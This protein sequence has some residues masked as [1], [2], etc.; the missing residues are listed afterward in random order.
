MSTPIQN[1]II[2]QLE[3][4]P[5]DGRW[6]LVQGEL[7]MMTPSGYE[8]SDIEGNVYALL[9]PIVREQGLGRVLVGE[10]G[11]VL[12]RDP[13]TLRAP[14]VAFVCAER[15]DPN[16]RGFF[17]GPPDLAVEVVSPEDRQQDVEAKARQWLD[18]GTQRVWI[19]W[20]ATRSVTTHHPDGTKQIL[21]EGD[22]LTGGD[23]VPG[24]ECR[25]DAI[26]EK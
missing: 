23:L 11:F 12:K 8:H 9:R 21:H 16:E 7:V 25:V 5:P 13:D 26:F 1:V 20:P 19:V 15:D 17:P 4:E 22:T 6:E 18:A 10:P 14:D 24:F 2:E 3:K